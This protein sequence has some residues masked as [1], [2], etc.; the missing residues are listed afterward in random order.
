[1]EEKQDQEEPHTN[2]WTQLDP[3]RANNA[4]NQAT[5][6]T[7]LALCSFLYLSL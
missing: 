2:L 3:A 6:L 1:M 5:S 7:L 4:V